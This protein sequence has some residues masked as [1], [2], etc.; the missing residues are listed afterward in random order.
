MI[1]V[2]S[3]CGGGGSSSSDSSDNSSGGF[4]AK[5]SA[6]EKIK[7]YSN[8]ESNTAPSLNDYIAAGVTGVT[9]ETLA[10]LNEIVEGL[11]PEDVDSTSEL[12]A[13]TTQLG[14]N[15]VPNANSG[16]N[17]SVQVN[18]SIEIKG[19]GTDS[20]GTIVSYSWKKNNVVLA[21][22][23]SF[24]YTPTSVGTDSLTLTVTDN[25]GD[26]ASDTNVFSC[27]C[28][29]YQTQSSTNS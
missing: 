15:I 24:V 22:I 9:S 23:A 17:Q 18:K 8:G 7:A 25:D 14:I 20:D 27:Y 13:L 6:I 1:L 26:T 29:T 2:L 5:E 19:S 10:E 11:S 21:T 28:G 12:E 16:G 4:T 3:A